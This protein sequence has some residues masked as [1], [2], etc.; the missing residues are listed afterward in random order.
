MFIG[1][2]AAIVEEDILNLDTLMDKLN[3][4]LIYLV[5]GIY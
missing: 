1:H 2:A 5:V 3:N 4:K